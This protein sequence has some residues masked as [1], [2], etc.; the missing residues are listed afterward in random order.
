MRGITSSPQN[1]LHS[2]SDRVHREKYTDPTLF[3]HVQRPG[4]GWGQGAD[5]VDQN[6]DATLLERTGKIAFRIDQC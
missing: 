3:I 1:Q 6:A 2:N 5:G 4:D